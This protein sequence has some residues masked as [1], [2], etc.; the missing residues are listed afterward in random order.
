MPKGPQGQK[1]YFHVELWHV[2]AIAAL[3]VI[4]LSMTARNLL[5]LHVSFLGDLIGIA[6]TGFLLAL[7]VWRYRAQRS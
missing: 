5:F 6:S 2:C 4:A 7:Y 3:F 1:R